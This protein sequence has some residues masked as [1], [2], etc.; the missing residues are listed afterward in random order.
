MAVV[1]E[2]KATKEEILELYLNEVYLGQPGLVRA[3]RRGRGRAYLLR[4]GSE[5]PHP[6]RE[7]RSSRASS[8]RQGTTRRSP[9][10]TARVPGETSCC[11]PWPRPATSRR[12]ARR[13]RFREP[14]QVAARARRLRGAVLRR[15]RQSAARR[16][17]ARAGPQRTGAFEVYTTLDLNLQR[18]A[19]DAVAG[20]PRQVDATLAR[21][22]RRVRPQA[23]LVAIDPRSGEVLA[24][25]GGR[26]YNQSQFNRATD[27]RRQP[28][29]MFK[30]F[31]Y[32]AAFDQAAASVAPTSRRP[33]L[34][35]DEPTTWPS[36]DGRLVA[37]Q[38]RRRVRRQDHA[39]PRAG[40][41]AQHRH[42]QGRRA[43]RLRQRRGAVEAHRPGQDALRGYP[44]I[45]LGVFELTPLEVA[46]AY[47]IF[48]NL[49]RQVRH[50][51]RSRAS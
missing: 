16:A 1:L 25:V 48:P 3:A 42:D 43:G 12:T 26:S 38:L 17:G 49:G 4:Q 23:A 47:T 5:Q 13:A 45:A 51:A 9:T 14:I 46:E 8:S 39:A 30:P 10:S 7:P 28:G 41:V 33:R 35:S 6:D 11:A 40:A 24:L 29:S 36:T 44:S 31:V 15:L 20:G 34:V 21:R 2:T 27:A 19:Q 18:D 50:C 32:L 37:E 22:K